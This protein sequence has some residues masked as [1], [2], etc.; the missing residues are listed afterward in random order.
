MKTSKALWVVLA[1]MAS[2]VSVAHAE[3]ICKVTVPT[4]TP[5]NVR[6]TPNGKLVGT[7][8]N[9]S[10]INWK[11]TAKDTK[12]RPWVKMTAQDETTG[13]TESGW[14]IREFVSCYTR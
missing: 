9:G 10:V 12:G 14:V 3:T 1:A 11:A 2:T 8:S 13:L 6:A 5:L 4:C 7:L